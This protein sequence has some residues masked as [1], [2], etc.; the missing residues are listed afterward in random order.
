MSAIV[1]VGQ[2]SQQAGDNMHDMMTTKEVCKLLGVDARTLRKYETAD[3]RW[4][5]VFGIKFRVYRLGDEPHSQRRY[6]RDEIMRVV[7]RLRRPDW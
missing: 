4:C 7:E 3:G 6:H 2:N 5:I 1:P